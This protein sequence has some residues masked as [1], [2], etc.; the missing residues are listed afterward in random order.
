MPTCTDL[1]LVR[2]PSLR[3]GYGGVL[4]SLAVLVYPLNPLSALH[5]VHNVHTRYRSKVH[6]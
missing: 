4:L 5:Y 1:E 3:R 6:P 2:A